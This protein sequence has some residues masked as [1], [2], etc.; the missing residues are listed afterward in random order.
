MEKNPSAEAECMQ[1]GL[2]FLIEIITGTR[3]HTIITYGGRP[4]PRAGIICFL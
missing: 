3:I 1:L 2:V 4:H